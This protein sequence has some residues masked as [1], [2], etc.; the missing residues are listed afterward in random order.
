MMPI[1]K[2]MGLRLK[3]ALY[4]QYQCYET[5]KIINRTVSFGIS[6]AGLQEQ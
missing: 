6:F 1:K 4:F 2:V 3:K 5:N